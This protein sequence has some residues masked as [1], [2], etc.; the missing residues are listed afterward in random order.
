MP[1]VR[2]ETQQV[3]HVEIT[4]MPVRWE[5]RVTGRDRWAEEL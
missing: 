3:T 5:W 2:V 4:E 1:E